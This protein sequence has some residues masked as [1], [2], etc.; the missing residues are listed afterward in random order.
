MAMHSVR[1]LLIGI[2]FVFALACGGPAANA[3]DRQKADSGKTQIVAKLGRREIT[4]SDLRS[5]MA[6]SGLSPNEPASERIALERIITRA[7]L[8]DAARDANLHRQPEAMRRMA[9]AQEQALADLYLT[10]ASQPPEP[11]RDEIEQFVRENPT[12]F[13]KRRAYSFSVLTLPTNNFDEEKFSPLFDESENFD[14]L[15]VVLNDAN[16]EFSVGPARQVANAFPEAI[17]DQLA[18]Y[19]ARDNIVIKGAQNTQI[20][21]ITGVERAPLNSKDSLVLARNALLRMNADDRAKNLLASL[22]KKTSLSYYRKSA[23]PLSDTK[24]ME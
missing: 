1:Q 6:R 13:A 19:G 23:A 10:T 12:L 9:I 4:I 2:A 5:E 16:I 22:R 18:E 3:A 15:S 11:T 21:K 17:R 7:L 8:T 24:G 14:A 20:M